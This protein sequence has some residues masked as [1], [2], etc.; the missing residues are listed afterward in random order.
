MQSGAFCCSAILQ[1]DQSDCQNSLVTTN[2]PDGK[3][4]TFIGMAISIGLS[5]T[6]LNNA[7]IQLCEQHNRACVPSK[8][9]L[10]R[11]FLDLMI[12]RVYKV[13]SAP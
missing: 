5:H 7:T 2:I 8:L 1:M 6:S 9:F 3:L 10:L 13:G 4:L 11:I 12:S